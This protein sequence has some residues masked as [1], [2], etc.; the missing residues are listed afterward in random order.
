MCWVD[1]S[2]QT[3]QLI[4]QQPGKKLKIRNKLPDD[5]TKNRL[6]FDS[7][8]ASIV[9]PAPASVA[10]PRC[11]TASTGGRIR[12]S[13]ATSGQSFWQDLPCQNWSLIG[14]EANPCGYSY[15]DAKLADGPCKRVLL[16]SGSRLK[17]S[18]KGGGPHPLDYDLQVGQSQTPVAVTIETGQLGL[19]GAQGYCAKFGGVVKKDGSDGKTFLAKNA[20]APASCP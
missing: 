3:C 11:G 12:V 18:C 16:R 5:I 17:A 4:G 14:S 19:P 7:K 2:N 1:C 13:S 10:D 20:A 15:K 6:L 8:G 9:T